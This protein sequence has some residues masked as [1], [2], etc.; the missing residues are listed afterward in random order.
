MTKRRENAMKKTMI[1]WMGL[2]AVAI[3]AGCAEGQMGPSI[4][5]TVRIVNAEGAE[6]GVWTQDT[7][8][9]FALAEAEGLPILANFTGSDWCFWCKMM[10]RR[11]FSSMAWEKWAG[12]K[13]VVLLWVDFPQNKERVPVEQQGKNRAL[14]E[15]FG[16]MGFPSYLVLAPDGKTVWGK[17][18]ASQ[19]ATAE[20]FC[21]AIDACIERGRN[22]ATLPSP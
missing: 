17:L 12:Q 18:G 2:A 1:R 3:L 15:W 11:V 22:Q 16:V 8:A 20:E 4:F 19:D 6:A 5:Q 9:G 7:D 21:V 14:A 13:K 10:D